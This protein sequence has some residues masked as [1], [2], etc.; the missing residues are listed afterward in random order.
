[1]NE[2]EIPICNGFIKTLCGTWLNIRHVETF[3]VKKSWGG[4]TSEHH[5]IASVDDYSEYL[6]YCFQSDND[7][8]VT[9]NRLIKNMRI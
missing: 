9:L 7:A 6:I 2:E 8:R 3:Y 5:I 4:H 1:M